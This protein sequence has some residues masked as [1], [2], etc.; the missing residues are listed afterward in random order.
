MLY[1]PYIIGLGKMDAHASANICLQ[2]D[3]YACRRLCS[4]CLLYM[5]VYIG[6]HVCLYVCVYPFV[7]LYVSRSALSS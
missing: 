6:M 1:R 3:M 4:L 7:C 5:L 2:S